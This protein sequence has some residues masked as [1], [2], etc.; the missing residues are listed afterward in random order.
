MRHTGPRV[1]GLAALAAAGVDQIQHFFFGPHVARQRA[2]GLLRA[3]E[4]GHGL[5]VAAVSFS[6]IAPRLVVARFRGRPQRV[7]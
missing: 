2:D 7:I 5:A 4:R 3:D 6:V 1:R